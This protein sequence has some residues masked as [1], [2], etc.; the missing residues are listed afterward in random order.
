MSKPRYPWWGYVKNVIR[1]YPSLQREYDELHE[2]SITAS[3]SGMPGGNG[4]SR[5]TENIALRQ[6]P[7]PKQ[8]EYEA[9]KAAVGLTHR[10]ATGEERMKVVELVFWKQSHTLN[11]AA[12]RANISYD[13]AINYHGDFI[14]LVAY[15]RELITYEEL[16]DSQKFALKS[17]KSVL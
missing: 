10:M 16:R 13:T 5:G 17:H 11:G 2:Q 15:F 1:S 8:K 9:V 7:G 12:I 14:M 4:V 6:L 3:M